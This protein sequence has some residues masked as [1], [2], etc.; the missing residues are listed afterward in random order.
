VTPLHRRIF[1][2]TLGSCRFQVNYQVPVA[3]TPMTDAEKKKRRNARSGTSSN[4][5]SGDEFRL[6]P[7]H[8]RSSSE[9]FVPTLDAE[10]RQLLDQ[11]RP[12]PPRDTPDANAPRPGSSK[13]V[14]EAALVK[15]QKKKLEKRKRAI[16]PLIEKATALNHREVLETLDKAMVSSDANDQSELSLFPRTRPF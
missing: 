7:E 16:L 4:V 1:A 15:L 2:E 13:S 11:S 10:D 6:R 12:R 3:I 8:E 5:S 9:E 14:E